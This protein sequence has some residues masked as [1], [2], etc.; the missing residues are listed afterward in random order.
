MSDPATE[1]QISFILSLARKS[2]IHDNTLDD[3][4]LSA[5]ILGRDGFDL[6]SL[7]KDDASRIIARFKDKLRWS[8]KKAGMRS[9][10][11]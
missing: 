4:R 11:G 2:N 8:A 10:Y 5:K 7:T 3:E 6:S 9:Y 1:E